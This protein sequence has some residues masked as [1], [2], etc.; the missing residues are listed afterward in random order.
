[1]HS[2]YAKMCQSEARWFSTTHGENP[3]LFMFTFKPK[4]KKK[5]IENGNGERSRGIMIFMKKLS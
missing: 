2:K 3:G 5:K 4:L 1:M